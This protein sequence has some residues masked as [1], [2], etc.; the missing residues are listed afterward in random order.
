[1]SSPALSS[2]KK[3]VQGFYYNTP[4]PALSLRKAAG[5]RAKSDSAPVDRSTHL[6]LFSVDPDPQAKGFLWGRVQPRAQ[7][8]PFSGSPLASAGP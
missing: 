7:P 6:T 1:M 2:E 5:R 3:G 4:V 8:S